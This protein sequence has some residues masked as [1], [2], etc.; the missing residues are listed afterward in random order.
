M[1]SCNLFFVSNVFQGPGFYG[2]GF[3]GSESGKKNENKS[4]VQKV[5]KI[6]HYT[7]IK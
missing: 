2:P 3:S 6:H 5:H 4:K 1:W 7:I